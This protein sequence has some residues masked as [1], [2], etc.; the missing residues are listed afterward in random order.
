MDLTT[1]LIILTVISVFIFDFTNGFHDSADMVATAIASRAMKASVAIAIVSIF[2]FLGPLLAG[3]AV[4][5]TVGTFVNISNAPLR[6]AQ[7]LVIAAL[8]AA[9]T[10]NLITWRF[11]LPSSSSNSL[12]GG[13]VGAGLYIVGEAQINW[14][15]TALQNGELTGV[16][17]VV[18]GLFASPFLGF[19]IGFLTMKIFFFVFKRFTMKIRPFF[20]VSQYF[21]VAWLGFSHGANDAQKGMAIIG[22]MLLASHETQS[23]SIPLWV[24]LMC[25]T[26]ITLGTMFGGWSIIKTLGFELYHVKLIHSVA[27]Q[28]GA[29]LVNTLATMIGAPTS[30]TQVVTATLLGNGAAEKPSHVG[31]RRATEIILGWLVN[32]PTSMLFGALY[33]FLLIKLLEILS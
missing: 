24:I 17:K 23:F 11:G 27:N 20:V 2:T 25:T 30:T 10:Y 32:V 31:W 5:D 18:T 3:L 1:I 28:L 15:I 12:A 33:S 19:I 29:A 13:L 9:V 16:L 8:L 4:A 14:G 22:M 26:A 21:S 7:A 6:D